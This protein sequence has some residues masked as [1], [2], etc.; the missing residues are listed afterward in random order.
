MNQIALYNLEG[1]KVKDLEIPAELVQGPI[2]RG[3]IYYMVQAQRARARA[4]THDTKTRGD[5]RG[6]TRKIY[7]QKGTGRARHGDN[8][9]PIFVG[10]GRT[11][12]PH[13]RDY[14]FNLPKSARRRSLQTV[15]ALKNKDGNLMV[16]QN[17][18]WKEPK[19]KQA[20]QL[21]KNLKSDSALLILEKRDPIVEKSVRN[22]K[23]FKVLPAEGLNVYDIL[24]YDK[25]ILTEESLSLVQK[26]LQLGK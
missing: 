1:K 20:A 21:F 6:S 2:R 16:V 9:A 18:G 7:R 26:R 8:Q 19:T 23:H 4:G 13:P 3:L 14:S 12:G 5:V 11:F 22:L 24:N 17:P 10:G 15:L 25:L